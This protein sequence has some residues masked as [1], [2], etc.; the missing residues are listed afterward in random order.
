ML[1]ATE[2]KLPKDQSDT[3]NWRYRG[4]VKQ[5]GGQRGAQRG[6]SKS[7]SKIFHR[8]TSIKSETQKQPER[9]QET[10]QIF[11]IYW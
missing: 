6:T 2:R 4:D 10:S 5:R 1:Q 8:S 3:R 9:N 11:K 7:E